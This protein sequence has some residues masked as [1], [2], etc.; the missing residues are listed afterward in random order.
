MIFTYVFQKKMKGRVYKFHPSQIYSNKN[1]IYKAY[2]HLTPEFP[3]YMTL[4]NQ[5]LPITEIKMILQYGK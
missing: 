4:K 5:K 3:L 1:P 2:R